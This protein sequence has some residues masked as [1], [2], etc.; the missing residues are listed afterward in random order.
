MLYLSILYAVCADCMH[1]CMYVYVCGCTQ[2]YTHTYQFD[3]QSVVVFMCVYVCVDVLNTTN[4]YTRIH[5]FVRC[6]HV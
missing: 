5:L 1:A 4:I 2:Y 3:I 6:I